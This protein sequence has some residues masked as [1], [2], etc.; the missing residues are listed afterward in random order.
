MNVQDRVE[1]VK[2]MEYIA[3]HINDENVFEGWL[4]EGVADGDIYYGDLTYEPSSVQGA[5]P[6]SE[7][8]PDSAEDYIEDRDFADLMDTFLWCMQK[9]YKSG[10][11]YCDGIVSKP[12]RLNGSAAPL[13][14]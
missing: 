6:A 10:G 14:N 7:S 8:T 2:A 11:L 5:T 1:M 3:R 12:A 13:N 4:V 9:A